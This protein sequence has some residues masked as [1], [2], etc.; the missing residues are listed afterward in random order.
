MITHLNYFI[1]IC[2]SFFFCFYFIT[3]FDV[4]TIFREVSIGHLQR[5]RLAN[6]LRLF[7]RAHGPVPFGTCICFIVEAILS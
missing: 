6:R 4:I 1:D 2:I 3:V 5:M 7:I